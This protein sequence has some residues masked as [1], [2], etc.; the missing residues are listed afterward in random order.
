MP[1]SSARIAIVDDD[2]A[3]RK[4][5]IRLLAA[6]YD[7]QA[8][9]SGSEFLASLDHGVPDCLVI[10]LQMPEMTG[11]DLQVHLVRAGIKIPTIFITA[12]DESGTRGRCKAA[13]AMAYLLKPLRKAAL[14]GAINAAIETSI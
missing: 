1:R 3:V 13:G 7:A 9:E 2:A 10:D 14:V 6:S 12:H 11:L 8:F 4:A 5:L